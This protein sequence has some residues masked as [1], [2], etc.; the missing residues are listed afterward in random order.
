M[1]TLFSLISLP[2]ALHELKKFLLRLQI[3]L[4]GSEHDVFHHRPV[5]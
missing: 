4:L 5:R 1:K 3:A 2:E